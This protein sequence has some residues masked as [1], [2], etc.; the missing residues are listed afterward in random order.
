MEARQ[1]PSTEPAPRE[2]VRAE[3]I[4]HVAEHLLPRAALLVRLL[5]KQVRSAEASRTEVEVL[6]M[7]ADRSRRVTEL[8]ELEGVAQPTMTF[9]VKR[10][11][12]RGWVR[13]EALPSDGRV[14]IISLTPAGRRAREHFRGR[15]VAA[16]RTDLEALP[17]E[18]LRALATTTDVLSSFVG[19]LQS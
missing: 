4:D 3:L 12:D 6:S 13:R 9:V 5:V 14:A 15:F 2:A 16:M 10:L 18:R 1:D 17:D 19:E 11:E 8:A 7:L